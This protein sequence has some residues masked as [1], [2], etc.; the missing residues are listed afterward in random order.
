MLAGGFGARCT[1]LSCFLLGGTVSFRRLRF[2]MGEA[3]RKIDSLCLFLRFSVV[4]KVAGL[5][6]S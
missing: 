6:R 1:E 3:T 5:K 2:Y 4:I